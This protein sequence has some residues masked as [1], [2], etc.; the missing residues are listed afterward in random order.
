[1]KQRKDLKVKAVID[2]IG[3]AMTLIG[4]GGLGGATEGE[5]SFLIALA[6]FVTG[7]AIVLWG[8]QR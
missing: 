3:A 8:Y 5:G 1:M 4:L 6:V 7:F 2:F